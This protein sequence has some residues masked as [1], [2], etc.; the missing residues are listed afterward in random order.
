MPNDPDPT[1][2]PPGFRARPEREAGTCDGCCFYVD[3]IG[4]GT[5]PIYCDPRGRRDRAPCIFQP[6]E[7]QP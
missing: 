7:T 6:K 2:A 5:D 3:D 1:E 4:C